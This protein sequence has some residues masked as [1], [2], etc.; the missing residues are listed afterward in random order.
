MLLVF[1][2]SGFMTLATG[3]MKRTKRSGPRTEPVEKCGMVESI[4]CSGH[5]ES[6]QNCDFSRVNS[7][8]DVICEFEQR[9]LSR[10]EFG[11]GRLQRAETGRYGYMRKETSQGETFSILPIVFKFEM[12]RKF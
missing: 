6:S 12:G 1:D 5:V 11:I 3:D 9:G 4:K 7:F 2:R 8:H 10:M